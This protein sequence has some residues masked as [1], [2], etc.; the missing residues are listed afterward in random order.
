VS[1]LRVLKWLMSVMC[2]LGGQG[3]GFEQRVL[4]PSQLPGKTELTTFMRK[5]GIRRPCDGGVG[6]VW[7][8]GVVH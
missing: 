2:P 6:G 1:H 7:Y 8:L 5:G 4:F 3:Q